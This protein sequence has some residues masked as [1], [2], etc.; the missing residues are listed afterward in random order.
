[1]LSDLRR[2]GANSNDSHK[3]DWELL[4]VAQHY[5]LTTRLLDWTSIHSQPYGLRVQLRRIKQDMSTR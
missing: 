3:D 2:F 5:G 1:M 4:V